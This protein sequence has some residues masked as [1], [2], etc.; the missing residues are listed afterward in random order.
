VGRD[1]G[2]FVAAPGIS[3]AD[4]YW[5]TER[6]TQFW[7]IKTASLASLQG[8][9]LSRKANLTTGMRLQLGLVQPLKRHRVK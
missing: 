8:A 9:L 4:G 6:R 2:K 5:L 1:V 3:Y 7:M